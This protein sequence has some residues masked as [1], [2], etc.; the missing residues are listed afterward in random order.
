MVMTSPTSTKTSLQQRLSA[1]PR[2]GWPQL[3]GVDVRFRAQFAYV[4]GN[5]ADGQT[6][7]LMRLRYGGSAARWGFAIYLAS[8]SSLS[9][10]TR[11][12]LTFLEG[13]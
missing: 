4:T 8:R 9:R 10:S 2:R 5:L 13:L 12:L 3:S 1:R 11:A 7:P 6:L